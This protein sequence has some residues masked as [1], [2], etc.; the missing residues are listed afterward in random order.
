VNYQ[1]NGL[2]RCWM[3]RILVQM[4]EAKKSSFVVIH[5]SFS[6]GLKLLNWT[7]VVLV[8]TDRMMQH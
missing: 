8:L 5:T 4:I 1:V 6:I 7:E 3:G 2:L